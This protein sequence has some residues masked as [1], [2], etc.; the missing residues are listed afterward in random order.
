MSELSQS[1]KKEAVVFI[2]GIWV[3]GL[4]MALLRQRVAAAGYECHQFRYK[5]LSKTPKENA[6]R[7]NQYLSTLENDVIH[8]VA[9]SLGGIVVMHLFHDF[10]QQNQGRVVL[11]AS[12]IHG[13]QVAEHIFKAGILR[14]FLGRSVN[15][16]LLGNVPQWNSGHDIGMIAGTKGIGLGILFAP[17]ALEKPNDGTVSLSATKS[18]AIKE[19]YA[20]PYSHQGMLFALPV[21]N[22]VCHF[23]QNGTF[24]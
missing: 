21:A 6:A 4:E 15:Q 5:S 16:G 17:R 3:N 19:H 23:L 9:H 20:V 24:K 11:L 13:S 10:P 1:K 12:P 8:L 2:H 18:N 7:L 22:L 14:S